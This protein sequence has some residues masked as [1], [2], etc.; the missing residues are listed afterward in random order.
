MTADIRAAKV[1]LR[2]LDLTL[3]TAD[4]LNIAIAQRI[5]A[6]LVTFDERMAANARVLGIHV[7]AA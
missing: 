1:F 7:V 5:R 3:R 4:A 2:R 6:A